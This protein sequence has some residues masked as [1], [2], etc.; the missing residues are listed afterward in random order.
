MSQAPVP[1]IGLLAR[2]FEVHRARAGNPA[3]GFMFPGSEGNPIN[4]DALARDVIAPLATHIQVV[5]RGW[6]CDAIY[7]CVA[8]F[9]VKMPLKLSRYCRKTRIH[10]TEAT[11]AGAMVPGDIVR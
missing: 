5:R 8:A 3:Y 1:V 7:A 9:A 4:L 2:Q 6:H 10:N 11:R